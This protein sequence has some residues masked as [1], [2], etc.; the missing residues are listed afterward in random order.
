MSTN[1]PKLDNMDKLM[2]MFPIALSIAFWVRTG[3]DFQKHWYSQ[4]IIDGMLAL[5]LISLAI[6]VIGRH[7][8]ELKNRIAAERRSAETQAAM[9]ARNMAGAAPVQPKMPEGLEQ[10]LDK[11][12]APLAKRAEEGEEIRDLIRANGDFPLTQGRV[13]TVEA[14]YHDKTGKYIKIELSE[15]GSTFTSERS[16][17][18]FEHV[19]G[20][21]PAHE[22]ARVR[23]D[24]ARTTKIPVVDGDEPAK[25]LTK[26]QQ[27]RINNQKG[28]G[29]ITDDEVREMKNQKRREARAAKK[30]EASTTSTTTQPG[31][32]SLV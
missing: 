18:P 16:D 7:V 11:V 22:A 28:F 21:S 12:I 14:A 6:M 29:P 26:S 31:Q 32:T 20:R 15:D 5:F 3:A 25:P 13:A 23:G 10:L 8:A 1:E 24:K 30:T 27:R 17:E 2:L 4:G 9:N 19:P